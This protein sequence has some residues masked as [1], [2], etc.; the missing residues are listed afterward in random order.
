VDISKVLAE[1]AMAPVRVGLLAADTGLAVGALALGVVKE[2]LGED[3]PRTV[4]GQTVDPLT[5]ILPL[6]GAIIGAN[7]VAEL[8][9]PDR[10][11]GRVLARGGP[12]DKLTRPGGVVDM[13]TAPGGLIDR[14]SVEGS[15]LERMLA[16]GGLVDRLLDEDG[17]LE[18]MFAEDGVIERVFAE[19][20][21]VDKLTVK[22]GPLEQLAETAEILSRLQPAVEALTP[23]ADTLESAVDTLNRMVNSL[24]AISDRIPRRRAAR[25]AVRA[26]PDV[27][28]DSV[29]E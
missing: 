21:I 18:R 22:D 20:G 13:L 5:E 28:D 25:S 17:P 1:I 26:K 8:T 29:N 9:E 2:S 6:R 19:D 11:L 4:E 23:T 24:S 27:D 7:R 14:V 10:A 16:P 12:A 3:G 15:S